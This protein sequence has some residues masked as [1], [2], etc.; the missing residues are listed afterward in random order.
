MRWIALLGDFLPAPLAGKGDSPCFS[1]DGLALDLAGLARCSSS[2]LFHLWALS[3]GHCW[4]MSPDW[5]A[6]PGLGDLLPA[7]FT[8]N[9]QHTLS[10]FARQLRALLFLLAAQTLARRHVPIV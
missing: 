6:V 1:V 9:A 5:F 3:C 7:H 10:E 2:F 4:L 8:H